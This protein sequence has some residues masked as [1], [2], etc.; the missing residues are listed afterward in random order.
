[1]AASKQSLDLL[2]RR[3]EF[4]ASLGYDPA[5][6]KIWAR[7]WRSLISGANK[8]ACKCLLSFEEY[9]KLAYEAGVK[10]PSE[11][12]K[13]IGS[14]QMG[15]LG[16]QG[17]Y[18]VGNCRFI[19]MSQNLAERAENGGNARTA[20]A[21]RKRMTGVRKETHPGVASMAKKITERNSKRFKAVSPTG[22]VYDG[23][24]LKEFSLKQG[25]NPIAMYQVCSGKYK[26]HKGWKVEYIV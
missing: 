17:D 23:E 10:Q 22:V 9:I 7:K 1:M 5:E 12:G 15:R 2:Y 18:V 4:I 8:K 11:I 6:V 13:S 19:K 24:N 16:D 20:E 14:Y 26:Q 25:L 3:S 21:M